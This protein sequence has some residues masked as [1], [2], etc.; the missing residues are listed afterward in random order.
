MRFKNRF[1]LTRARFEEG[2]KKKGKKDKD[3]DVPSHEVLR[4]IREGVIHL[5]GDY[6]CGCVQSS[7]QGTITLPASPA[8]FVTNCF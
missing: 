2:R 6:G 1:L 4:A 7:L 5:H 3:E 8:S